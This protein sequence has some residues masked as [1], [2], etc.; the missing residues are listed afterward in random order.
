MRR[1]V[2]SHWKAGQR[3][4]RHPAGK[5]LEGSLRYETID[6]I[7]DAIDD[8]RGLAIARDGVG[9]AWVT[10]WTHWDE[11]FRYIRCDKGE[12]REDQAD[13]HLR[14]R[15]GESAALLHRCPG[16]REEGGL[17]PGA[18]Q[19]AH[20]RLSRGAGRRRAA[21]RAQRQPGR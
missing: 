18:V 17:H 12:T 9:S 6:D 7:L 20:R 2:R 21:A 5:H 8:E 1:P 4:K 11:G 13:Q 19:V 3:V 10:D 15:P 16:L 14:G